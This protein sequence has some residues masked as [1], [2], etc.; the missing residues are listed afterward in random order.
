MTNLQYIQIL[1]KMFA[2]HSEDPK[3]YEKTKIEIS[4]SIKEENAEYKHISF[5]SVGRNASHHFYLGVDD[6]D[7]VY[8]RSLYRDEECVW[9][10]RDPAKC[11]W[12]N[13]DTMPIDY[14]SIVEESIHKMDKDIQKEH[15][16]M[17]HW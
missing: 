6:S 11:D 17:G 3:V 7:N 2:S 8:Y 5:Y 16:Y 13:P 15:V 1:A 9:G 10:D 4:K 14:I 12:K